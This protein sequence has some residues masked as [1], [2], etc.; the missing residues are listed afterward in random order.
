MKLNGHTQL[1]MSLMTLT[2]MWLNSLKHSTTSLPMTRSTTITQKKI[3]CIEH[4]ETTLHTGMFMISTMATGTIL[5][6]DPTSTPMIT[7]VSMS[8]PRSS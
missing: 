8:C 7:Q 1:S 2:T 4:T 6:T 3:F 5:I